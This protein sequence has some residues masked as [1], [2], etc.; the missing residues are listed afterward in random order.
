MNNK[1]DKIKKWLI[2]TGGIAVCAVLVAAIGSQFK[3]EKPVEAPLPSQ[4]TE[5]SEVTVENE[6]TETEKE[7]I[8]EKPEITE[9]ESTDIGA[10]STGTEQTIQGDVEK[11]KEP[12]P[13]KAEDGKDRT[14]PK[15]PSGK[16]HEFTPESSVAPPSYKPEET[17][18]KPAESKP[19][20]GA[21]SIP[22]FDNVPDLG[23]NHGEVVED[24][25][26][27]GNKVG[28]MD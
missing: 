27:N 2:A 9:P 18:K 6:N 26:E 3:K 13:P 1:N 23:E 14:P 15:T 28:I 16:D 8:I 24:M 5:A 11:P 7:V 10:A 22:G 19:S 20:G 25:Y 17:E 12:E 21:N 4:S